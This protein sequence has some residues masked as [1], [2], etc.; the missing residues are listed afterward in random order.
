MSS[1][2]SRLILQSEIHLQLQADQGR[3][4]QYAN[5]AMA[6]GPPKTGGPLTG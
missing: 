4:N 3:I 6:W 1:T 5:Y 2:F